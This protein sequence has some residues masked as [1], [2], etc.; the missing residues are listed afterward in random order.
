MIDLNRKVVLALYALYL[1]KGCDS[2]AL[3]SV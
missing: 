3:I 2:R 1:S